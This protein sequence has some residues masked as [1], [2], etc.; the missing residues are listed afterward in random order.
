MR[1][2]HQYSRYSH[3]PSIDSQ[4][5]GAERIYRP[6]RS[7]TGLQPPHD[8]KLAILRGHI[9]RVDDEMAPGVCNR[10]SRRI[11]HAGIARRISRGSGNHF[12]PNFPPISVPI[13]PEQERQGRAGGTPVQ[14]PPSTRGRVKR[15]IPV[16]PSM[17]GAI[18]IVTRRFQAARILRYPLCRSHRFFF[19]FRAGGV[20][21]LRL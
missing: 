9:A 14:S 6:L 13:F 11:Y 20:G 7:S 21:N 8:A 2:D 16:V 18:R 17:C 3:L 1:S 5:M 15:K 4:T 19:S 12:H 10:P